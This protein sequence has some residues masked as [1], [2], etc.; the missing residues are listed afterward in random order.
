MENI[1][2]E[3]LIELG[4]KETEVAY[5][6]VYFKA[7]LQTLYKIN[8]TSR[9]ASRILAPLIT[10]PCRAYR[11]FISEIKKIHWEDFCSLKKTFSISASVSNSRINNSL[12]ASQCL[13]DG[14]AD[15]FRSKN[16]KRPDVEVV[17]PDTLQLTH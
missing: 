6:G 7:D 9:L 16:G 5:K 8:Y 11:L 13:K 17:N 12:Y 3:E 14:I 15:Y 10:F 2:Q 4:A 1:C